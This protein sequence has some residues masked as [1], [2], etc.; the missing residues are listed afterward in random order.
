MRI[1]I[2]A[3]LVGGASGGVEQALLGLAHGLAQLANDD[4]T[5]YL[6]LT[7]PEHQ[8][9]L[10][11][12]VGNNAAL[13][14]TAQPSTTIWRQLAQ[15]IR[16]IVR[17]VRSA[18]L[19]VLGDAAIAIPASDGTLERAGAD[20]VHFPTQSAFTTS[21][22]SIYQPWDL[23]HV[24]HPEYFTDFAWKD[25]DVR[26]RRFCSEASVVVVASEWTKAD[27][28]KMYGVDEAKIAVIPIPPPIAA[29]QPLTHAVQAETQRGYH[30]PSAY[31]F[32]P[33]QTWA[34][35]NH[36][37]LLDAL[38]LVRDRR[39]LT[40]PLVLSGRHTEYHGNIVERIRALGLERQ[41]VDLGFISADALHAIL[42][43]ATALVFPSRFE[44]WGLPVGEAF[45]AGVPVLCAESTSLTEQAGDAAIL[46]NPDDVS[47]IARAIEVMWTNES[48][49]HSLAERGAARVA[50]FSWAAAAR[51]YRDQYRR[52]ADLPR[53]AIGSAL[54][55]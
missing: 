5:Q 17:R 6:F 40:V 21:L 4:D 26:Y 27:L 23:Q 16:P 9:W 42:T 45:L 54:R 2:D 53:S 48:L 25:R 11:P 32:Y 18:A 34:H 14:A 35:K 10:R 13:I 29:Y 43:S 15:P 24:H 39:G 55:T 46:F 36:L 38:A 28:M 22:P 30:L 1:G 20:L 37:K 41:V 7:W 19:R 51:A 49:R 8:E 33:A 31:F 12:Y 44:G 47:D 3:R 52:V 50:R